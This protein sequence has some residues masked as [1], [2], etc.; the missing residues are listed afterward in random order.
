MRVFTCNHKTRILGLEH[1]VKPIKA[2]VLAMAGRRLAR[3]REAR[4][5]AIVG[6][7]RE[8]EPRRRR[9]RRRAGGEGGS[10][11]VRRLNEFLQGS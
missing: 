3:A 8:A 11:V 10:R 1:L 2:L 4:R 9:A 5:E 6:E 7:E